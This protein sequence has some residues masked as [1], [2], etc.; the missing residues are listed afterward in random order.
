MRQVVMKQVVMK[1]VVMRRAMARTVSL[2]ALV[3][4]FSLGCAPNTNRSI[5]AANPVA[6]LQTDR[7]DATIVLQD[8]DIPRLNAAIFHATNE[9]RLA[10]GL[11]PV[12]HNAILE[13]AATKYAQRLVELDTYSHEDPET[14]A[15][16][17]DRLADE[18][19]TNPL[20]AENLAGNVLLQLGSGESVYE[21]DASKGLFSRE[22][23]GA[24]IPFHTYAS[25]ARS[26]VE[27]WMNSP[28]HRR[29]LLSTDALQL[30]C[31]AAVDRSKKF[32]MVT[33]VQKFQFYEPITR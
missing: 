1:Q 15:M 25:L 12:E 6:E 3:A 18:G 32:P 26:F 4:I 27:N 21:L 22:P 9:A 13:Q 11:E 19:V 17:K 24:P 30:G 2:V 14:G 20:P 10:E 5:S 23:K 7:F 33:A 28:G 16:P 31:G 8:F 29:N